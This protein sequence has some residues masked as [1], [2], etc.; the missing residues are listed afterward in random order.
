MRLTRLLGAAVLPRLG[1]RE[2][3][4]MKSKIV[5]TGLALFTAAT[6]AACGGTK[7]APTTAGGTTGAGG[8]GGGATGTG[9]SGGVAPTY[10]EG[11]CGACAAEQCAG[12]R[13]A[14]GDDAG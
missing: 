5:S 8:Q 4:R 3:E 10:R 11:L 2:E 14:C 7:D 6:V 9:G 12:D 13:A 1:V